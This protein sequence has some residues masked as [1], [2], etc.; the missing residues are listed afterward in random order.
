[1][2]KEV[3]AQAKL[4]K[5]F[6]MLL[7]IPGIG[8]ILALTIMFEVGDIHRFPKVGNY[9]SYCRCVKSE[10]LSN[11]KKKGENNRKNGNR[12]LAWAYVE[13]ANFAK[14]YCPDAQKFWQR[15][16][17]KRNNIVAIKA[18]S[19][20]IARASYYVMRDQV[21]FDPGKLFRT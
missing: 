21:P 5:E 11:G 16:Q 7:S 10:R 2:E 6:G 3:M 13:A 14:R 17:A 8:K 19:N 15:K 9:S 1:M 4:R 12:Y 20:K 18:L